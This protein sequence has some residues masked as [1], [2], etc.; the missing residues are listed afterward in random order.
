MYR[1]TKREKP[2]NFADTVGLVFATA[3][4]R[5]RPLA[6]PMKILVNLFLCATQLGFCCIYI[7]FIANNVKM[8]SQSVTVL[9]IVAVGLVIVR[10][11]V[12][13]H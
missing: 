13:S 10:L 1:Q 8:V 4:P 5:L 3:S 6:L 7:V 9:C 2:P 12:K 11:I